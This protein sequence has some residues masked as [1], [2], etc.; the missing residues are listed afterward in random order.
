MVQNKRAGVNPRE[1]RE[2]CGNWTWIQ[3]AEGGNARFG[4]LF[5]ESWNCP[6]C[7]Q[8]KLSK[9]VE[10]LNGAEIVQYHEIELPHRWGDVKLQMDRVLKR[11]RRVHGRLEYFIAIRTRRHS[12]TLGL[13]LSSG[14][15]PERAVVEAF[16]LD[17]LRAESTSET[18]YR[19]EGRRD[20]LTALLDTWSDSTQFIHRVRHSR[21]FF[22]AR[23]ASPP[24]ADKAPMIVSRC[25]LSYWLRMFD[26]A[27]CAV[28]QL[29]PDSYVA[30]G[31]SRLIAAL[32]PPGDRSAESAQP[33]MSSR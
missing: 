15:L 31:G 28:T 27:G 17:G 8:V 4:P 21:Q 9:L 13:F 14:T 5:C 16:A 3:G 25:P 23:T 11:W 2:N 1:R 7:R 10:K 29:G 24:P 12:T 32:S 30:E 20:K 18:L 26:R 22:A 33:S 19:P 6:A